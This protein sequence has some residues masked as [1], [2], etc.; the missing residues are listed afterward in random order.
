MLRPH[1]G[2][3]V[4]SP[5]PLNLA[6]R[7]A[8]FTHLQDV[9]AFRFDGTD[10]DEGVCVAIKQAFHVILSF[11]NAGTHREILAGVGQKR[12]PELVVCQFLQAKEVLER[13]LEV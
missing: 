8:H 5:C 10:S 3:I 1:F 13:T 2:I 7:A 4:P 12:R 6:V 9:A 11:S